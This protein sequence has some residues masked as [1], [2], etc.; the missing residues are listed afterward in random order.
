MG[1]EVAIVVGVLAALAWLVWLRFV[2]ALVV[3]V[4]AQL[5]ELRAAGRGADGRSRRARGT[6]PVAAGVGLLAQR[7]VAAILILLPVATGSRRRSPTAR[8]RC[9]RARRG[10]R[11]TSTPEPAQPVAPRSPATPAA[12]SVVVAPGDTLIGLARQHLG[13]GDRWREIFE[14]NR[15]RPQA[16]GAVCSRRARCG[17]A[18]RCRCPPASAGC[19][20]APPAA[21]YAAAATVTVEPDD[22]LWDLAQERLAAAGAAHDD[23]AVADHVQASSM[24]TRTSSRTRT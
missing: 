6:G 21:P 23:T 18:G 24:P 11:S 5:A 19:A 2:V 9:G 17:S 22:N 10:R 15:D 13:D 1:D 4:R 7:L 16:D 3:E 14:L 20:A 12:G 8:R